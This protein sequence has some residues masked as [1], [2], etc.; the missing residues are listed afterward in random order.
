MLQLTFVCVGPHRRVPPPRDWVIAA[1]PDSGQ[2]RLPIG[3]PRRGDGCRLRRRR[4]VVR[5]D[6]PV[7]RLIRRLDRRL[8]A[9]RNRHHDIHL[10]R[11]RQRRRN[12]ADDG[13]VL[14]FRHPAG[15]QRLGRIERI[16]PIFV[17]AVR[18][19]VRVRAVF[20]HDALGHE[21]VRRVWRSPWQWGRPGSGTSAPACCLPMRQTFYRSSSHRLPAVAVWGSS[22]VGPNVPANA[23]LNAPCG[24]D[25]RR[26]IRSST[27]AGIGVAL[28]LPGTSS[29]P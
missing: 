6:R 27:V 2:V 26:I 25:H 22:K 9:C 16:V 28:P 3:A 15:V 5:R 23:A 10:S 11:F 29:A 21:F 1:T 4:R 13:A 24:P 17:V 12:V 18:E 8:D 19:L 14:L 7:G 20:H